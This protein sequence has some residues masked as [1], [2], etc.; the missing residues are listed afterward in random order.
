MTHWP[1]R[2]RRGFTLIELMVAVA[3]ALVLTL[4]ITLMLVRSES[5][6]RTL[7]STNDSSNNGAYLSYV[8]DRTLRSA[9]SGFAQGWRNAYGCALQAQR[10]T[11]GTFLP[12]ASAYPAPFASVPLTMRM[13]PL[14]VQAGTGNGGSDVLIVQTGSSGL[15]EAPLPVLTNSASSGT[16]SLRVPITLGLRGGDLVA[17]VQETNTGT[18][19]LPCVLQQV[20]AGFVGNTDVLELGGNFYAASVG[21]IALDDIGSARR[22]WVVP[23]GNEAGSRP[24][25]QL[26]GVAANNTLV[27]YDLLR[28]DA[29]NTVVP[30]ADGVVD[31]RARYGVDTDDDGRIDDW[32]SPADADWTAATLMNGSE[33]AATALSRIIAVRVALVLRNNSPERTD[34]SPASLTLFADLPAAQQATHSIAAGDRSLRYRTL[35]FTV[36]LRNALLTQRP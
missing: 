22:A 29:S 33:A 16:A 17:L 34:I 35:D 4:A 18:G 28:L 3:I 24:G 15:G 26:L 20:E 36:P 6:R 27:S 13:A 11:L 32:V 9:G 12:R 2:P 10:A 14:V 7:T 23:L 31:L 30:V 19:P 8:L 25:F 21:G 1:A 5:G